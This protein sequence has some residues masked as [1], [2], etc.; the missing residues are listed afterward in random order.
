MNEER[1]LSETQRNQEPKEELPCNVVPEQTF[2]AGVLA[3]LQSALASTP[4]S[5]GVD[6][7]ATFPC[8]R[9]GHQMSVYVPWVPAL[10]LIE[11]EFV[12]VDAK[13][14]CVVKHPCSHG[15]AKH[16][17]CGQGYRYKITVSSGLTSEEPIR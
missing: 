1:D 4:L 3:E 9:C 6:W 10:N 2:M 8:P 5:R 12:T 13:C 7:Q 16:S 14:N 11:Q 17:G 15:D